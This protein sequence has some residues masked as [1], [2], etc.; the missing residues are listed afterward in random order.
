MI[1]PERFAHLPASMRNAPQVRGLTLAVYP[2]GNNEWAVPGREKIYIVRLSADGKRLHCSCV[3]SLRQR[4]A[5]RY[6][7]HYFLKEQR[8]NRASSLTK[9]THNG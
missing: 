6:A 9:E 3:A 7:V 1:A 4:C 2:R 8:K 5:H